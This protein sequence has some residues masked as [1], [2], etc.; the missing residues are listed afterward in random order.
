MILS[1]LE[2]SNLSWL[3]FNTFLLGCILR[4]EWWVQFGVT[5]PMVE[6]EYQAVLKSSMHMNLSQAELIAS[7]HII[8]VFRCFVLFGHQFKMYHLHSC[9]KI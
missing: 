1:L 7:G 2:S 4:H 3:D 8:E 6:N 5:W 9:K